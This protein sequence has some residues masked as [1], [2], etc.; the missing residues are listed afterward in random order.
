[1]SLLTQ[2]KAQGG[3]TWNPHIYEVHAANQGYYVSL[4][5]FETK[6]NFDLT[7]AEFNIVLDVYNQLAVAKGEVTMVGFWVDGDTLYVDL[8]EHIF[9][10]HQKD[11]GLELA[12]LL[13][14]RRGQ[15]AIF[16]CSTG[17]SI[18]L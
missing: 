4:P 10:L 13:G 17:Q 1:M 8:S 7:E 15:K 18:Y 5:G 6:F 14:R 16:D 3:L 2:V 11:G 12:V 9:A